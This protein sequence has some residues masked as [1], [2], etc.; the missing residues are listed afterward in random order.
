MH[1]LY[2]TV[3]GLSIPF[4]ATYGVSTESGR[5]FNVTAAVSHYLTEVSLSM[6]IRDLS[7]VLRWIGATGALATRPGYDIIGGVR[8][9][10]HG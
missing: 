9:R 10:T 7:C 6:P 8:W 5:A 4:L 1:S 2:Q 3:W